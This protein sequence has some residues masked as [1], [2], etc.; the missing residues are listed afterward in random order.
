MENWRIERN[1][2]ARTEWDADS[3]RYTLIELTLSAKIRVYTC[4]C[5]RCK[6]PRPIYRA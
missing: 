6:G 3:R 2:S 5:G 4:P 1:C